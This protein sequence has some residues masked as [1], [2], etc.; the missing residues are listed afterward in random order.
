[1]GSADVQA[2]LWGAAPRDWAE[3]A[4]PLSRPL[5]EATVADL[6]GSGAPGDPVSGVVLDSGERVQARW[7]FGADGQHSIV[8]RRLHLPRTDTRHAGNG[9]GESVAAG[10]ADQ[11]R[12][13][14][15]TWRSTPAT[16]TPPTHPNPPPPDPK[17]RPRRR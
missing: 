13:G 7:T 11:W 12:P 8:A 9:C 2:R 14:A 4:E 1:M 15:G 6:I 16:A 10:V 5:H 17:L 3:V